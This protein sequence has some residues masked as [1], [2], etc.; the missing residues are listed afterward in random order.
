MGDLPVARLL[1]TQTIN[2]DIHALSGIRA[3]DPSV[4]AS[5]DSSCLTPRG[6]SDR[7]W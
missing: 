7:I 5:E 6:H 3:H 4:Q 2:T 1:P